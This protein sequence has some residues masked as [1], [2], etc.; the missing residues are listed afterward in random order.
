MIF[1]SGL[2][3]CA[4]LTAL[5]SRAIAALVLTQKDPRFPRARLQFGTSIVQ[6]L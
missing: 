5:A 4:A 2:F 6:A 1:K 3:A